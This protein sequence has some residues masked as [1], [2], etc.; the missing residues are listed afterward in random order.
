ML[1]YLL[2]VMASKSDFLQAL[3]PSLEPMVNG[4]SG[5]VHLLLRGVKR[6]ESIFPQGLYGESDL[7]QSSIPPGSRSKKD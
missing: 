5:H 7:I 2:V 4:F 3:S 1:R 6:E